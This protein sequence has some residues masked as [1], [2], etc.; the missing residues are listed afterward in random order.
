MDPTPGPYDGT[1]NIAI[2]PGAPPPTQTLAENQG[3]INGMPPSTAGNKNPLWNGISLGT[4]KG[5]LRG[6]TTA[7]PQL[8][9]G[10]VTLG[11]NAAQDV[12]IVRRPFVG[13]TTATTAE[14][15]FSQASF[16]VLLSDSA[17][18]IT[19]LPA[20]VSAGAPFNLADI[21]RDPA[22]WVTPN[23]VALK[24][25]MIANGTVVLPMAASGAANNASNLSYTAAD[26]YWI[27]RDRPIEPGFIKIEI[28]TAY[29]YPCGAW[30]DVT[31]D[32]LALGFAGKNINPLTATPGPAIP[33]IAVGGGAPGQF[34][35]VDNAP[36][37]LPTL[38]TQPGLA[39]CVN[40]HPN[41]IIR[42]ERIRDNP[43]LAGQYTAGCGVLLNGL[44]VPIAASTSP[45]DYWPN[46]LFD[47]RE[48]L[49]R[50]SSPGVTGIPLS[51]VMHYVELDA[52]NLANYLKNDAVGKT[53]RDPNVADHDFAV[54]I[55]DRRSNYLLNQ[56][57]AGTWPSLSPSSH[58]T[59]EYG[60]FDMVNGQ[61]S[62]TANSCP[63]GALDIG[64]DFDGT[65]ILYTYGEDS[66]HAA[67][68]YTGTSLG[69]DPFTNVQALALEANPSCPAP[70]VPQPTWPG[71]FARNANE[72]RENP[73][74]FFRRAVK[75][76]NGNN[77]QL[78]KCPGDTP[79]VP[80]F[81]GL[82]IASENP[83]YVM[84]DYNANSAGGGFNDFGVAASVLGD[85]VTFLSNN[86][87]DYNS[88]YSPYSMNGTNFPA[89][90][91]RRGAVDTF[92]RTAVVG[93]KGINFPQPAGTGQ[94]FGTDGGVHNFLRYIE[95]WGGRTLNYQG[96]LISLFYN[97][98]AIGTFKC[99]TT[100]YSPPTRA[101]AFDTN[102]LN[103][104]FLPPRTPLF[105]DVNTTGFTQLL[106]PNQ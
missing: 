66:T 29:G 32:V 60:A 103:P 36:A 75:I 74:F 96:S 39:T 58:E 31:L 9:L 104:Q 6:G 80:I 47:T 56:T 88:F 95:T 14:R 17:N 54:Y 97:R 82:T 69:Y 59:G 1:V 72:A 20:C 100:V 8:N 16:R 102:F 91:G 101:Y 22:T 48:G 57:W 51:G 79:A 18:D 21:A 43:S 77:L 30:Q 37:G 105:R 62:S 70:T 89:D 23:A 78:G 53:S 49:L 19:A 64:E 3:S 73:S 44:N 45:Y 71:T 2:G 93:G 42:L 33:G 67:G 27:P 81:C 38:T 13:E 83:V 85:A 87:N 98:Q 24:N 90:P 40:P 63:S 10:I 65:N 5:Y 41:A 55:S 94:D 11:N 61:P 84:G 7:A 46:T 68:A 34:S 4:F 25:K 50:D 15:Y 76:V 52:K 99:C 92:Y 106:L 12:D 35:Q 26:G 86:W 28:Q